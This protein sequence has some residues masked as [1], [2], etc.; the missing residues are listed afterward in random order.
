MTI[1]CAS[2]PTPCFGAPVNGLFDHDR[3]SAR[4]CFAPDGLGGGNEGFV[5]D[6]D[7]DAGAGFDAG[8]GSENGG[9]SAERQSDWRSEI[10]DQRLRQ[11][12]ER[13]TSVEDI[14]KAHMDLR[15][16]LSNAVNPPGENADP[17]EVSAFRE[18][19]GIPD[20]ALGYEI[21]QIEGF[22]PGDSE[23]DFKD[24]MAP[25]F[26]K[27]NISQEAFKEI[28][29][30]YADYMMTAG[31]DAAAAQSQADETFLNQSEAD[32]RRQWGKD[33]A[34]NLRYSQEGTQYYFD[35][36]IGQLELKNG[37]LLGSHPTFLKGMAQIGR[38][39]GE[40]V[41]HIDHAGGGGASL[42]EQADGFREKRNAAK[43]A[44][45]I[46]EAQRYDR[47]ERE[48]LARMSGGDQPVVG[49]D[50]RRV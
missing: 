41:V 17:K 29:T 38:M 19:M 20:S 47:L 16:R 45:R 9:E 34:A 11:H 36:D 39:H 42:R 33:Y 24:H 48:T 30:E 8:L 25:V 21:P 18:K 40:G 3:W 46:A 27:H 6:D 23:L 5:S 14:A 49:A 35:R 7:I 4:I 1:D 43:A 31:R 44:G 15:T 10:G 13:F 12:A 32:L 22:Q 2:T 26:H 50:G 28:T 37:Q